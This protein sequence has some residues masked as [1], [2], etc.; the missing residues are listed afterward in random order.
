MRVSIDV[1]FVIIIA[2]MMIGAFIY[3][4][5]LNCKEWYIKHK[6]NKYIN[7]QKEKEDE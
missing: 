7:E 6:Y 2:S 5:I 3:H 1:L 4:A